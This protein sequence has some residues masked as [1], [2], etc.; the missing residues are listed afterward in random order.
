MIDLCDKCK[1]LRGADVATP[2]EMCK[3]RNYCLKERLC[4]YHC[5]EL[6]HMCTLCLEF[7]QDPRNDQKL[8]EWEKRNEKKKRSE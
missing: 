5:F 6:Y 3:N 7:I 4:E 2:L 1:N 8:Q